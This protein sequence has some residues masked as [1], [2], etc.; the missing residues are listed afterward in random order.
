MTAPT[1]RGDGQR[2]AATGQP[3]TPALISERET[4]FQDG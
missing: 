1:P 2:Q 3:R 4:R